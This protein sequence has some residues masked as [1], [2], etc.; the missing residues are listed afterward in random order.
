MNSFLVGSHF[1]L[2]NQDSFL[3]GL[4]SFLNIGIKKLHTYKGKHKKSH[5]S[6]SHTILKFEFEKHIHIKRG[7][8]NSHAKTKF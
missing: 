4:L 2:E 5:L 3:V 7:T 1:I 8:P 6:N